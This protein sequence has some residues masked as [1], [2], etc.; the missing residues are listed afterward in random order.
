M[1]QQT[2][3]DVNVLQENNARAASGR[4]L[5]FSKPGI[6]TVQQRL[7]SLPCEAASG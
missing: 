1:V 7:K 4:R 6:H 2:A 5:F 3:I